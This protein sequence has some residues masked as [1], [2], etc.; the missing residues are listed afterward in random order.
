MK[1]QFRRK[2]PANC[3]P[4]KGFAGEKAQFG[5]QNVQFHPDSAP[6]SQ[7]RM[8][9]PS[10]SVFPRWDAARSGGRHPSVGRLLFI[11]VKG[12]L[13]GP[14]TI[15][16]TKKEILTSLPLLNKPHDYILAVVESLDGDQHR[17]HYVRRPY[18][19]EPD[20]GVT[21]LNYGVTV[22]LARAEG[23]A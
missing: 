19:R 11:E 4:R 6:P 13:A 8:A 23:P 22:L 21:S 9:A 3:S 1:A 17:A 16:V 5:A 12:R 20:L 15:T 10:A 7:S 14:D 2:L 18:R